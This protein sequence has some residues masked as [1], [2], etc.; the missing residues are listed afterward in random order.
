MKIDKF[1]DLAQSK[2]VLERTAARLGVSEFA[3]VENPSHIYRP[4]DIYPMAPRITTPR[5]RLTAIVKDMDGTTTT[6]EELTRI[7]DVGAE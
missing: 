5:S 6:T 7:V 4:F 2:D 1:T 3:I